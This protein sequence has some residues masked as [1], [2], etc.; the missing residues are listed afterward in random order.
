MSGELN[1]AKLLATMTPKLQAREFVFATLKAD[2]AVESLR[3]AAI[4]TFVEE[5]GLTLIVPA[6][7]TLPE[8]TER[9]EPQRMITLQVHSSLE[10]VGLTYRVSERLAGL[11]ISCNVV[12][13]FF[14]DHIFVSTAKADAAVT[15]LQQLQAESAAA[16]E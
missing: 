16:A 8:G 15:A 6:D 10:A 14:H 4:G 5:E 2:K 9:S 1:L 12:A 11:G 3:S 7:Q 13:A